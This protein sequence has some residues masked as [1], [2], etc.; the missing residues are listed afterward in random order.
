MSRI[1]QKLEELK[2]AAKT[3]QSVATDFFERLR[4]L[5]NGQNTP[6]NL[7]FHEPI[8]NSGYSVAELESRITG[9]L[10]LV[11]NT[12]SQADDLL[13]APFIALN[14]L[15]K[16]INRV[17]E[18][19]QNTINA[20]NNIRNNGGVGTIEDGNYA[21]VST[22][23][24]VR[25]ELWSELN[26]IEEP[27]DLAISQYAQ[28]AY[29]L[30]AKK[31]SDFSFALKSIQK[32]LEEAKT[33]NQ[34]LDVL[35]QDSEKLRKGSLDKS[36]AITS[37]L[38]TSEEH[39]RTIA[40]I[41]DEINGRET[42]SVEHLRT[43]AGNLE[44]STQLSIE[45][46]TLKE[47]VEGYQSTFGAFQKLLDD[48]TTQI[49]NGKEEQDALIVE[50]QKRMIEIKNT[51]EQ[52]KLMLSGATTAGL[53]GEYKSIGNELSKRLRS[54][55]IT[56][57]V[58]VFLLFLSTLPLLMGIFSFDITPPVEG[59]GNTEHNIKT[60]QQL[61]GDILVRM[62][63]I[64]PAAWLCK[65]SA[66]RHAALFKLK[67]DYA[68]KYSVA[69]SVDGFKKQSEKFADEIAY[70]TFQELCF[71]PA[72]KMDKGNL[73]ADCPQPALQKLLNI[74]E[75]KLTKEDFKEFLAEIMDFVKKKKGS[76]SNAAE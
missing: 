49:K 67:E 73:D 74:L 46:N 20:L 60:W 57:Y 27:L 51:E 3:T 75:N 43:I 29:Y 50:L 45:S 56:F 23:G 12:D 7:N 66:A 59:T 62:V 17:C 21:L 48:R 30:K 70:T 76:S 26:S 58:S 47:T 15:V 54:A 42:T 31:N 72:D 71:N 14:G 25:L 8:Q 41:C 36:D 16:S 63:F 24:A 11:L 38:K 40:K 1:Q 13:L 19:C 28:C 68:Y 69:A 39:E 34:S 10:L 4:Y 32:I 35:L 33:K 61:L 53:A 2:N 55:E 44:R 22:N 65:F 6:A 9:F 64:I 52:S 18:R 5:Q 37:L